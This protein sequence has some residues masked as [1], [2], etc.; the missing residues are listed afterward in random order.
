MRPT[1]PEK[2]FTLFELAVVLA[3]LAIVATTAIPFFARRAEISA[4]QKTAKEV[5]TIQ[6]AAKWHYISTK[7]WPVSIQT[8]KDAGFLNPAWSAT[9]PWGS[10]YWISSIGAS[11]TVTTT[12][13]NSAA[14]VLLRALPGVSS[15]ANGNDRTLNS[16]IPV[17]GQE[18]SLTEVMNLANEALNRANQALEM[19]QTSAVPPYGPVVEATARRFKRLEECP[20]GYVVVAIFRRDDM[21]RFHC[22]RIAR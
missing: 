7:A 21:L 18:A 15:W 16:T 13:P 5:S 1:G 8:L 19:A 2:G 20:D 14:G 11:F 10:S 17:P 12:I 22:Q 3:A 6:E 9:N 4:A